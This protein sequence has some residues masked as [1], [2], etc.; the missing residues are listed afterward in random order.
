MSLVLQEKSGKK[1][2]TRTAKLSVGC[3]VREPKSARKGQE[4]ALRLDLKEKVSTGVK[5]HIISFESKELLELWKRHI[6][7]SRPDGA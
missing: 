1:A 2:R 3:D 7:M 5:K 6:E 4:H